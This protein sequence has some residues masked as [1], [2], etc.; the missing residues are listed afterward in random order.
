LEGFSGAPVKYDFEQP[1]VAAA[2]A[3]STIA[4]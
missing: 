3:A 2:R 4:Q 1:D